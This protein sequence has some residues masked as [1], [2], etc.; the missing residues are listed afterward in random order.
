MVF[1]SQFA[2]MACFFRRSAIE[3]IQRAS[4][5]VQW[6]VAARKLPFFVTDGNEIHQRTLAARVALAKVSEIEAGWRILKDKLW[7]PCGLVWRAVAAAFHEGEFRLQD[8][9]HIFL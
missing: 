1:L 2:T 3:K 6:N 4:I 7:A 5:V 9:K 8:C